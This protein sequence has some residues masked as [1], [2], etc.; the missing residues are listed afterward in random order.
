MQKLDSE[1]TAVLHHAVSEIRESLFLLADE[2][3]RLTGCPNSHDSIQCAA[4]ALGIVEYELRAR[5]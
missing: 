2:S 1:A 4:D 3:I 5:R